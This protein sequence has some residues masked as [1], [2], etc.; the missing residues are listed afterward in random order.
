MQN[1]LDRFFHLSER[2]SRI[3]TELLAGAST[4]AAMAYIICV[5]PAL[6]SG[7]LTGTETGMPFA[8]LVTTTCLASAAGCFLM[9]LIANYPIGLAPGMGENFFMLFGVMGACAA[10][11]GAK[12]GDPVIWQ[13]ALAI[14]LTAGLLFLAISF[15]PL[16]KKCIDSLS[17]SL[18]AG[19]VAGLGLFIAYLGLRNS[20]IVGIVQGN[21]A[22]TVSCREPAP[23]I[24]LTGLVL[25]CA[26]KYR[27]VQGAI[28]Y[29]IFASAIVAFFCG[30]LHLSG[31]VG[32]PANPL[33]VI[34]KTDFAVLFRHLFE[35]LPLIFICFFMDL[36]DTMGTVIG[37]ADRAGLMKN[38]K[39]ERLERVFA[40]DAMATVT[41]A[42]LGHSTVTSFVESSAGTEAGGRTGLT[43]VT[44]GA[45]FLLSLIFSPLIMALASCPPVTSSALVIVGAMMTQAVKEVKWD[46]FSEAVP[47]FL[48]IG[49]ISF[50]NSIIGG[51]SLGLI[52]SPVVKLCS[53]KRKETGWF[54][55]LTAFFLMVYLILLN[56]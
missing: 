6:L 10:A 22:L 21:P 13:T 26:L 14:M 1:K 12:T 54:S 49:G 32:L 4:F 17:P 53:G 11:T 18:K 52:A 16:R 56:R 45:L 29:G 23:L 9:G 44:V 25:I 8:A 42:L 5:Q 38:G 37:V 3:R 20:G 27:K 7:Q 2:G 41:G 24:F 19:I 50:T 28:L 35:F 48:I 36:F 51:L 40:A 46:D 39:I 47:A 31:I 55:W 33:P 43:A 34:A 15:T 30:K